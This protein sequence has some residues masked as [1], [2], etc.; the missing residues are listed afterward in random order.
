MLQ[1]K[2]S[3]KC[4]RTSRNGHLLIDGAVA[5]PTGHRLQHAAE[6]A[7]VAMGLILRT[8]GHGVNDGGEHL[9]SD[10]M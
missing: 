3:D 4:S 1:V 10:T 2:Q 8:A 9:Q 5:V 7:S 6:E